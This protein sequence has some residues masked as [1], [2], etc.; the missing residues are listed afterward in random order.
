[1]NV[2]QTIGKRL[3]ICAKNGLKG[4][5]KSSVVQTSDSLIPRCI[6]PL[7]ASFIHHLSAQN[8]RNIEKRPFAP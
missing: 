6:H 3:A 1:M 8:S 4:E 2:Q 5:K 7:Q